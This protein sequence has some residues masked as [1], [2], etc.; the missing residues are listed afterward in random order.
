MGG[1]GGRGKEENAYARH[2]HNGGRLHSV[3]LEELAGVTL[4]G[5]KVEERGVDLHVD[6]CHAHTYIR[7]GHSRLTHPVKIQ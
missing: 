6:E 7:W 4:V 2:L 1:G 3:H 5:G